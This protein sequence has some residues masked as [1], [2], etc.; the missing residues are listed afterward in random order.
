MQ[1]GRRIL[2][3]C[4]FTLYMHGITNH[5]RLEQLCEPHLSVADTGNNGKEPIGRFVSVFNQEDIV[6]ALQTGSY[7]QGPYVD[8]ALTEQGE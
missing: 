1:H 6:A 5:E 2:R 7:L 4:T 8:A 3:V